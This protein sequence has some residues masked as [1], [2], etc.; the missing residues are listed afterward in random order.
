VVI[1]LLKRQGHRERYANANATPIRNESRA[2][3]RAGRRGT[4][5]RSLSALF[6]RVALS[7]ICA[8]LSE[9]RERRHLWRPVYGRGAFTS[10]LGS[11]TSP[12]LRFRRSREQKRPLGVRCPRV[13]PP[14]EKVSTLALGF[15][16]DSGKHER[17][18]KMRAERGQP[19]ASS[20]SFSSRPR[21]SRNRDTLCVT[22]ARDKRERDVRVLIVARPLSTH[23]YVRSFP[24]R[25]G[26]V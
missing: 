17:A 16:V 5:K 23:I 22:F 10:R 13:G 2:L 1:W 3:S 25:K 18:A 26:R 6:K 8:D 24:K 21:D 14:R 19:A 12:S 15:I 11:F 20:R 9:R 4:S 7:N